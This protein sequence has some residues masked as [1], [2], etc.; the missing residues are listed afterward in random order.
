MDKALFFQSLESVIEQT[1]ETSFAAHMQDK[2]SSRKAAQISQ[3]LKECD[4]WS[5]HLKKVAG[6]IVEPF[7]GEVDKEFTDFLLANK[8][9]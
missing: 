3:A 6:G 9:K 2:T 5:C 4:E 7:N 8:D 1:G